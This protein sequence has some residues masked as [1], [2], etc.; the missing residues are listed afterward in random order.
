MLLPESLLTY[1]ASVDQQSI[2]QH[3]RPVIFLFSV[4]LTREENRARYIL[5]TFNR[6]AGVLVT[7]RGLPQQKTT[8]Y[9]PGRSCCC[10]VKRDLLF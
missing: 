1:T 10:S 7:A 6:R 4:L 5:G 2:E 9:I 8:R 3:S